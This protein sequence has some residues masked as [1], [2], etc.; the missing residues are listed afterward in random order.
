MDFARRRSHDRFG[1]GMMP[2]GTVTFL[3]TDIEGST[4]LL[5]QL[6]PAY[7]AV[8]D[9]H[10]RLMR[11]AIAEGEGVELRTEG[12]AFFAVFPS[13]PGAVRAAVAAQRSLA[14]HPWSHG[15]PLRV[16]MGMHTGEGIL[17]GDDYLGIDVNRAARIAAAG[18]GGQVLLSDATRSVVEHDLPSGVTFRD[19]GKHRL[20][21]LAD[22]VH[23]YDLVIDD[24]PFE[25]PPLK[26]LEAPVVLP[27]QPTSFVGREQLLAA[28]IDLLDDARLVTLTGPGG[29]GKTRMAV[30][31]A[32]RRV[33]RF[34]DGTY[35][36]DL[37]TIT[38]P[39]V[40]PHGIAGALRLRV[41]SGLGILD[42]I[43][44]HLR[45][46]SVFLV[47]DN[48]EQVVEGAGVVSAIL[49]AAPG[50]RVIATS[51]APLGLSGE[52]ELPIP[53]LGLPDADA[54]P[55]A[56]QQSEA[57]AL[58]AERAALV[59]PAFRLTDEIVPVVAEICIRLDGLPLAIE[60]AASRVRVLP[61]GAL[62]AQLDRALPV[63]VGGPRDVPARQRT[64]RDAIA[65]SYDLLDEADR[66][67][68]RRVSVFAGG[69]SFEAATPVANPEAE[70][71]DPLARHETLLQHSL[72]QRTSDE[73]RFRMLETIREFGLERLDESGETDDVRN[74][75]AE[76]FVA[77]AE[78]AEPHLTAPD[79]RPWLDL[80]SREHDNIRAVL[81]WAV[82]H[83]R[84]EV[85]L[86]LGAALW[87][88]WY[89]RG[90]MEEGRRWLD[91]ALNLASSA[92]RTEVRARA[93]TAFGGIAYW[94]SD[95]EDADAAYQEALDIIE[96]LGQRSLLVEAW[97]NL[98]ETKGVMG[99]PEE[100]FDLITRSLELARGLG[101][102]RGE[103]WALWGLSGG[104]L[105]GGD[106]DAAQRFGEE[107]LRAFE[108][109]GTDSWGV[110]NALAML[111]DFAAMRGDPLEAR[112]LALRGIDAWQDQ[113]N[114]TAIA[115][116]LR[117]LAIAANAAG[118]HER[119]VILAG[120]AAVLREKA[121]A[122]IPDAFFPFREPRD[123]AADVLDPETL[124]RLWAEGRG[125][126]IEEALAI[127]REE[128]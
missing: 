72:V 20:K 7:G 43:T 128:W 91:A 21:D 57:V 13:A 82:D 126:T 27:L 120:A 53:P 116:Q 111:A 96:E 65:W 85:A 54:D 12:D 47:L 118:K 35:F 22:L 117:F 110:G 34:P 52:H 84:G 8:Q 94:Q 29:T 89:G 83:D 11:R 75:H 5:Q 40:V 25:F 69:W 45:E 99:H 26:T 113:G 55:V 62:L 73:P 70:L 101:D 3:F 56:L 103:A 14:S 28:L 18:H 10:M 123:E 39:R 48:F 2:T 63:L 119:A 44:Q 38:D 74:R 104:S 92:P 24:L 90:H 114:A 19:L 42:L 122:R 58:F 108:A 80:L 59:D 50:V 32:R 51:R 67:F 124:E 109:I 6:G 66:A 37:S 88:F 49:T 36:V 98:A 78:E 93:L 100:A 1:M 64:L 79:Q 31:A 60:L 30:E 95:F 71:G 105:F 87:R 9:D 16:R 125:M 61:P 68:F 23:L 112:E 41:E 81:T 86:R 17:G 115:L 77:M 107:S 121:A 4:K 33:E 46:R 15:R 76:V 127:A 106:L 97:F 102:R